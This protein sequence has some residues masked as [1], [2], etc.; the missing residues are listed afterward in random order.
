LETVRVIRTRTELQELARSWNGLVE[1][2]AKK[3][4][5]LTWEWVSNWVDVYLREARLL[6]VVV[7]DGGVPR[8]L[9]PFCVQEERC[10][11]VKLRV[12]RFLGSGEVCA[13][14]L[15]VIMDADATVADAKRIWTALLGPLRR[16]WDVFECYDVPP[17]SSIFI[18]FRSLAGDDKRGVKM[19][20]LEETV[21]PYLALPGSWDEYLEQCSGTRRY[22]IT[23][24]MRKLDEQGVLE[25]RFCERLEYLDSF[26]NAFISLHQKSWNERGEPGSFSSERF[27]A[28]HRLVARDFLE[29]GILFLCSFHLDRRHVGSFYGFQYGGTVYYYQLGVETNPVKRVKTGTAVIGGCIQEAI[30]RGCS[31]LDFLRG[32]EEYKYRWTATDRRDLR[33]RFY[34]RS[35]AGVAALVSGASSGLTKRLLRRVLGRRVVTLKRLVGR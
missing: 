14:H 23:Y 26:M 20:T 24:S 10:L 8:A 1:R 27:E 31:E 28:F 29:K 34:N 21:C 5:F 2:S 6:T 33:V 3:N 12:L 17:D 22:T 9:A 13:D 7:Y 16:E 30:R 4:V 32:E 18:G 19:E 25:R 11:G 15:D 35:A